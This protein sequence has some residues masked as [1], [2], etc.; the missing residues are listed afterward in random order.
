MI[1][2][3]EIIEVIRSLESKDISRAREIITSL[4]SPESSYERG[5]LH[6]LKGLIAS[7]DNKDGDS[8]FQKL[9]MDVMDAST[10]NDEWES[11]KNV[12][13]QNFRPSYDIGYE[14]AW[15]FIFS[16]FSGNAKMGLDK[17]QS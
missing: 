7:C 8:V 2:E 11:S 5:Y 14:H 13:A 9:I 3:L 12:L 16:Y 1:S 15:E 4:K 10:I 6:A 17:Y